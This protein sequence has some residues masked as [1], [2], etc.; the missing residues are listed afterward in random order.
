MAA[1]VDQLVTAVV[2]VMDDP[3]QRPALYA[4]LRADTDRVLPKLV[5]MLDS[6]DP[7][8][9]R[10]AAQAL[11]ALQDARAIAP[12]CR[13][14]LYAPAG[15]AAAAVAAL[16][17]LPATSASLIT[18]E[19]AL[20]APDG[21]VRLEA[22]LSLAQIATDYQ[23]SAGQRARAALSEMRTEDAG[24]CCEAGLTRLDAAAR[25]ALFAA[26][27][28]TDPKRTMEALRTMLESRSSADA[29]RDLL[30]SLSTVQI[31]QTRLDGELASFL[32]PF[33]ARAAR[34]LTIPD[35][36]QA[37][38][39][40]DATIHAI[41]GALYSEEDP[42]RR[43]SLT[44]SLQTLDQRSTQILARRLSDERP[45]DVSELVRI[46]HQ[47]GWKPTPDRAGARYWVAQGEFDECLA[48]GDEAIGPLVEAFLSSDLEQRDAAARVL[49][50][51]GWAPSD[52]EMAI[53]YAI[54]LGHFDDLALVGNDALPKMEQVMALERQASMRHRE[55]AYRE[56]KRSALTSSLP[57][58][59]GQQARE[60]LIQSLH[61]DPSP[62]VRRAALESLQTLGLC[63]GDLLLETLQSERSLLASA[64]AAS[65]QSA[66]DMRCDIA[67]QL[68][69]I[70]YLES[71]DALA[72][73]AQTD[74]DDACRQYA[75][76][77]LSSMWDRDP[78][79]VLAA[80]LT[81]A[82]DPTDVSAVLES[83]QEQAAGLMASWLGSHDR[84][85][86]SRATTGLI[87]LGR[88]R[89]DIDA[90][91]AVP[92][93]DSTPDVRKAASLVYERLGTQ[94][95]RPDLLAAFYLAQGR[96]EPIEEIGQPAIP[97]LVD[98]LP[99]L[100]W[101]MQGDVAITLLR[102]QLDPRSQVL[103]DVVNRLV[104]VSET[105]D[106]VIK[107]MAS[108]AGQASGGQQTVS[109]TVSHHEQR[110]EARKRLAAIISMRAKQLNRLRP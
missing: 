19:E 35:G 69:E 105:P 21:C 74:P 92:L 47:L 20:H 56:E 75:S 39:A 66:A 108:G 103:D 102:L 36:D 18:L 4:A 86:A 76:E 82:T 42:L 54:S 40:V 97:V 65:G 58:I 44:A 73:M 1:Q 60:L 12:L 38:A 37:A 41:L 30:N 2:N 100:D 10:A 17:G 22:A 16:G 48:A 90:A 51:L 67:E 89:A 91:L 49:E 83:V 7:E 55:P 27:F 64:E 101:R 106:E 61:Q 107:Q 6:P 43:A 52:D 14:A 11:T 104:S 25:D 32:A 28:S 81:H 23:S 71:A 15:P 77:A 9:A 3:K 13:V 80:L 94:P 70:G 93:M 62:V 68:G 26:A 46:L 99:H 24:P 72:G 59:G 98:A 29:A 33:A 95:S 50:R 57:R 8:Y 84:D 109:L 34:D 5:A 110:Q 96:V 88:Q 79:R 63:D 53:P 78:E 85:K 45:D 31:L 87:A